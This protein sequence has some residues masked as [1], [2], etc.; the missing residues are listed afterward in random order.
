MLPCVAPCAVAGEIT[1]GI[2]TKAFS[3]PA[4]QQI[5]PGTVTI[6]VVDGAQ[7]RTQTARGVGIFLAAGDVAGIIISPDPCLPG[8][9]VILP[10]Q[11]VGGVVDVGSCLRGVSG[12]FLNRGDITVT[13]VD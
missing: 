11:L 7:D 6:G 2:V 5:A 1:N 8:R 9:L 3:V 4:G 13:V 10:D 12:G